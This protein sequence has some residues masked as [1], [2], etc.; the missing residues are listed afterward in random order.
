MAALIV[1]LVGSSRP[2][3]FVVIS[4]IRQAAAHAAYLI[5]TDD[6]TGVASR[7]LLRRC[8]CA[9]CAALIAPGGRGGGVSAG[10]GAAGRSCRA[11]AW[12]LIAARMD[13][14]SFIKCAKTFGLVSKLKLA[15]PCVASFGGSRLAASLN[16]A[17]PVS[18][19][20]SIITSM[21]AVKYPSV[22]P[23]ILSSNSSLSA[24]LMPGVS[25]ARF[26]NAM[27]IRDILFPNGTWRH[28]S[29]LSASSLCRL[30]RSCRRLFGDVAALAVD[31]LRRRQKA[32]TAGEVVDAIQNLLRDFR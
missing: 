5:P 31:D 32:G 21:A 9:N 15:A 19:N 14:L 4:K 7:R 11:A 10:C 30:P 22:M 13:G 28:N 26:A 12:C 1:L 16:I 17:K 27:P 8:M 6:A 23:F 29:S 25:K 18:H 2:I 20:G 24:G 3:S